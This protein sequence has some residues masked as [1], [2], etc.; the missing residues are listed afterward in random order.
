M[1]SSVHLYVRNVIL[2]VG[3]PLQ[4]LKYDVVKTKEEETKKKEKKEKKTNKIKENKRK[5]KKKSI[6]GYGFS[7]KLLP[8][9]SSSVNVNVG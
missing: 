7:M 9:V 8:A 6:N 2:S 3:D 5:K 1:I 4:A